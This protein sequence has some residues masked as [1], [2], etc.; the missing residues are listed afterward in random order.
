MKICPKCRRSYED[1]IDF[2]LRDGKPL[3]RAD[4][5]SSSEPAERVEPSRGPRTEPVLKIKSWDRAESVRGS[6]AAGGVP[7]REAPWAPN[8]LAA[9]ADRSRPDPASPPRIKPWEPPREVSPPSPPREDETSVKDGIAPWIP[10][11]VRE[12]SVSGI[13]LTMPVGLDSQKPPWETAE[14]IP[15]RKVSVLPPGP[16]DETPTPAYSEAAVL[17]P[18]L[19]VPPPER[20]A[21]EPVG[22][23]TILVVEADEEEL[24]IE[25]LELEE[26]VPP[27]EPELPLVVRYTQGAAIEHAGCRGPC[28]GPPVEEEDAEGQ[29]TRILIHTEDVFE[30]P[31]PDD[32]DALD[33]D[34]FVVFW[35][36][37][38]VTPMGEPLEPAR[39][40]WQKRRYLVMAACLLLGLAVVGVVVGSRNG[41][42][43]E[44]HAPAPVAS[45][46]SSSRPAPNRGHPET[47]R[48]EQPG[49][50]DIE[51][52]SHPDALG[53]AVGPGT[54]L[55]EASGTPSTLQKL[56]G[57]TGD[58]G[59]RETPLPVA[60]ARDEEGG[61]ETGLEARDSETQPGEPVPEPAETAPAKEAR[62]V[63]SGAMDEPETSGTKVAM[64]D[65]SREPASPEMRTE[66]DA[67]V[68]PPS[69]AHSEPVAVREGTV[70]LHSSPTGA[71]VYVDGARVGITPVAITAPLGQHRLRVEKE[72]Y[73]AAE[74]RLSI[75][76][77]DAGQMSVS[78]EALPV[79]E[80]TPVPT[81]SLL[82]TSNVIGA[83]VFID[84]ERKG[85]APLSV[86]LQTGT[87]SVK[88]APEGRSAQEAVVTVPASVGQDHIERRHFQF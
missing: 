83:D 52:A 73:Q 62:N 84:G 54:G 39:R 19:P 61:G 23:E 68:P 81:F 6:A 53:K 37:K 36:G 8:P 48:V 5:E 51:R 69:S 87:H 18:D 72:G 79:R 57:G 14:P 11:Q 55:E 15:L 63:P 42:G 78:L 12:S 43:E 50:E 21:A 88:V 47:N 45:L 70:L 80:P 1:E 28:P 32:E 66:S 4:A 56:A 25:G 44:V 64:V 74:T 77:E 22:D 35:R 10:G 13:R 58:E 38:R 65:V 86:V 30:P 59:V 26:V 60:A 71:T 67:N 33:P 82:I 34:G 49:R 41:D 31:D 27:P 7:A 46:T 9:Q 2:C 85:T 24:D 76:R 20:E 75:D 3:V 29:E 40:A 17:T 16:V